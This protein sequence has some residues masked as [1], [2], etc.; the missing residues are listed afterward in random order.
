[1]LTLE[2]MQRRWPNGNQH[3]PGLLEGIVA[4]APAVFATYGLTTPLVVAH[5]MAQFSA[6]CGQ[7]LKMLE[8]MNYSA[9]GLL[10]T[11]HTHFTP[12]M[13]AHCQHNPQMIAEIVYGGRMGNAPPPSNDGYVF[14]GAGLAQIT[15]RSNVEGLSQFL[16]DHGAAFNILADPELIVD[17][18]HALEVGVAAWVRCGCLPCATGD[19]VTEV[20]KKLNGGLNGLAERQRQFA[21][22]KAEFGPDGSAP[23]AA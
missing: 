10:A 20:T 6:E 3:V 5:A 9:Q 7:G 15:G 2:I 23:P 12:A 17:P 11:F 21:L 8:N 4:A 14:R 22:W 13:A 18:A 19:D 1:M 16:I